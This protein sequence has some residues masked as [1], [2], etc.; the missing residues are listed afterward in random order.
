MTADCGGGEDD[1]PLVRGPADMI[2][3]QVREYDVRHVTR[4]DSQG[5]EV[6]EQ[7]AA[8]ETIVAIVPNAI[9]EVFD[10]RLY[11]SFGSILNDA[12]LAFSQQN[13]IA[14]DLIRKLKVVYCA[15]ICVDFG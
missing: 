10:T 5:G 15:K 4:L 14:D 12:C 11:S 1:A 9:V 8:L 7:G 3:M 6:I 13:P 2:E